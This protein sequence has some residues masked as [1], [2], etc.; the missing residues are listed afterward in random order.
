MGYAPSPARRRAHR[1][2]RVCSRLSPR[3]GRRRHRGGR[4]RPRDAAYTDPLLAALHARLSARGGCVRLGD[5]AAGGAV[6]SP[7]GRHIGGVRRPV[8]SDARHRLDAAALRRPDARPFRR[9]ALTHPLDHQRDP[10]H[11]RLARML[12]RMA[13]LHRLR[14]LH[15]QPP[16][17][18]PRHLRRPVRRLPPVG[19]LLVRQELPRQRRLGR[20]PP[21]LALH[22]HHALRA[23]GLVLQEAF[24]VAL[25]HGA[26]DS[27]PQHPLDARRPRAQG[28]ARLL[29][30]LL[31]LRPHLPRHARCR[32]RPRPRRPLGER[33]PLAARQARPLLCD[34]GRA[35]GLR[36]QPHVGSDS[37]RQ[38]AQGAHE[39]CGEARRQGRLQARLN[40]S[41]I[42][43]WPMA[44]DAK[45]DSKLNLTDG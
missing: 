44:D 14:G 22:R 25:S 19:P 15:L 38:P 40:D 24:R 12:L 45:T 17:V 43:W 29:R 5:R 34:R 28:H 2:H 18:T 3:R 41:V 16:L 37:R 32:I 33:R 26:L 1:H 7:R 39:G 30:R 21:P 42:D 10:P 36:A 6:R 11:R 9:V 23:V 13:Q 35:R 8:W 31:W 4:R 27:L 20:T